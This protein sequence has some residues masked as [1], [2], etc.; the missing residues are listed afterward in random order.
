M[1]NCSGET[2]LTA[3][4]NQSDVAASQGAGARSN[5][6]WTALST[7]TYA[8][9]KSDNGAKLRC[10]AYHDAYAPLNYRET[11]ASLDVHCKFRLIV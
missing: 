11:D 1:L 6:A 8:F 10:V 5:A 9:K 3:A 2:E 7:L 4:A